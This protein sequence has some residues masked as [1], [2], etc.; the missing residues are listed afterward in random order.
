MFGWI[1]K[2]GGAEHFGK[3]AAEAMP[4]MQKAM[5]RRREAQRDAEKARYEYE[6]ARYGM[7]GDDA[8]PNYSSAGLFRV[9]ERSLT[10]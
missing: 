10:Y 4:G 3:G 5:D 8:N 1:I 9:G 2:A 6:M 7:C